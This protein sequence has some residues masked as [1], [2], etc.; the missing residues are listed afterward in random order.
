MNELLCEFIS[1]FLH[2]FLSTN[3]SGREETGWKRV[4][5]RKY[6]AGTG[7][8]LGGIILLAGR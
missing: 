4:A 1:K 8:F 3:F 7:F 2:N 5:G 6:L